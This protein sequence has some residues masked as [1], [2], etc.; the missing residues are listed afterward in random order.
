ML[1]HQG[2]VFQFHSTG[3]L[4]K[5]DL[6]YL[7]NVLIAGLVLLSA[8]KMVATTFALNCMGSYSEMIRN[9]TRAK[10]SVAGVCVAA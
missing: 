4:F 1:Y 7:F 10:F 3:Q 9:R 2:V 8:S 6:L 5:M